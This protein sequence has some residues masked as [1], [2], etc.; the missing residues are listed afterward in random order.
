VRGT[1]SVDTLLVIAGS[2]DVEP[3]AIAA[4]VMQPAITVRD[5]DPVRKAIDLMLRRGARELIVTD[6]NG[7]IVGF[8]DEADVT[9]EYLSDRRPKP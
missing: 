6:E 1:I 7:R 5:S 3:W 8:L 9:R 2:K 4:D